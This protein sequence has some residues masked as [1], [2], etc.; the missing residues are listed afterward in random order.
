MVFP[1]IRKR[2]HET[3]GVTVSPVASLYEEGSNLL[4]SLEMPGVDQKTLD[5]Q[6]SGRQLVIR[7]KSLREDPDS[8]YV[9]LLQ[10]RAAAEYWRSF[11]INTDIDRDKVSARYE[12]GVLKI[13]LPKAQAVLPKRIEV[14][15]S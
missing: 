7:G 2:L 1:V 15:S 5:I 11:E 13:A 14:K 8:G 10:E 6:L 12:D 4:L 3:E 9:P